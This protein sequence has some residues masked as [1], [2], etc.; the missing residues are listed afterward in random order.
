VRPRVQIPGPD[1]ILDLHSPIS[2]ALLS[3]RITAVSLISCELA[4]PRLSK[5]AAVSQSNSA[6]TGLAYRETADVI[7]TYATGLS[8]EQAASLLAAEAGH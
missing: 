2:R 6:G 8:P 3:R 5:V 4:Q 1:Q 7:R